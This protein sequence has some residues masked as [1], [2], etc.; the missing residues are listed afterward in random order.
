MGGSSELLT[1]PIAGMNRIR[2]T[3]TGV[4]ELGAKS[5]EAGRWKMENGV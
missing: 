3:S 5:A 1:V 2:M 4:K